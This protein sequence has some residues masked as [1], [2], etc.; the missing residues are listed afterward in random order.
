LVAGALVTSLVPVYLQPRYFAI[1]CVMASLFA[2]IWLALLRRGRGADRGTRARERRSL[3]D[4]GAVLKRLATASNDGN[5]ALFVNVA[6]SA[7]Q[8]SLAA[9]WNLA[10][11]RITMAE[12]D[13]RLGNDD[14]G[15]RQIFALADEVNYSGCEPG[16]TDFQRWTQIIHHH[17]TGESMRLP[18]SSSAP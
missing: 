4:A 10:P 15:V 17:L 12:L 3:R 14:E 16:A 18:K 6:S 5:T 1:P 13:A 9:R 8:Q 7:L 2:G 11:E